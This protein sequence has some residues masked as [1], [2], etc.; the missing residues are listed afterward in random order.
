MPSWPRRCRLRAFST[1]STSQDLPSSLNACSPAD[2]PCVKCRSKAVTYCCESRFTSCFILSSQ[3]PRATRATR[4]RDAGPPSSQSASDIAVIC[5]WG[6]HP[7]SRPPGFLVMVY[8]LNSS[9]RMPAWMVTGNGQKTRT[10][11]LQ[12]WRGHGPR[13]KYG[14]PGFSA[15]QAFRGELKQENELS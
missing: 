8:V 2:Q 3:R 14:G 7:I 15:T 11:C 1:R 5:K 13:R 10:P 4:P 12:A 6:E 9:T